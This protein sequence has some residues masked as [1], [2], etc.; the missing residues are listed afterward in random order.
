MITKQNINQIFGTMLIYFTFKVIADVMC[1]LHSVKPK[2]KGIMNN[3]GYH[4]TTQ[5][6]A[7]WLLE[8]QMTRIS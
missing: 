2:L 3:S 4:Q 8:L 7:F 1:Q 6:E 5:C